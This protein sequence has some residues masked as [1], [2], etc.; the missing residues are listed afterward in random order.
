MEGD[1][2][3]V[4]KGCGQANGSID[5]DT[6]Q[7]ADQGSRIKWGRKKRESNGQ[8]VSEGEECYPCTMV[9]RHSFDGMSAES[10]KTARTTSKAG[11]QPTIN[12]PSRPGTREGQTSTDWPTSQASRK[13]MTSDQATNQPA[14][15]HA[16]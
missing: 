4:C 9:R 15:T 3:L 1:G 2:R 10:L 8:T 16:D 13:Q 14:D 6:A 11:T 12:Q 7:D 5:M